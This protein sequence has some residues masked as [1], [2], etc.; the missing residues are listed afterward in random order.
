EAYRPDLV[1]I[2]AGYDAH[3]DDP[4]A[5]CLLETEDFA[6]MACHV[7]DLGARCG[8]PVGAVL[9]G[10]YDAGAVAS[11]VVATLAALG[12]EGEVALLA[13][14]GDRIVAV[15][16][17]DRLREPGTAEVA[18]ATAD[19][20]QGRG[21]ATRMLEQLAEHAAARGI[22]RFDAEVLSDNRRMLGVFRSAG[23]G[24]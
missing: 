5:G 4:L 20:F 16:G 10:G 15:A 12:G 24:I 6:D 11:G 8:A 21:V 19:D 13:R 18:F 23:F 14:H 7:R 3:R 2:S 17:Y 1:L 9:E 22:R